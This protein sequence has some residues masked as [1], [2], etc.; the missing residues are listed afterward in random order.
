MALP[1]FSLAAQKIWVAQNLGELQPPPLA[2]T[3]M[4]L[5][6]WFVH[7]NLSKT[8]GLEIEKILRSPFGNQLEKCSGQMQIFSCQFV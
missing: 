2:R 8:T 6:Q 5:S 7:P 4:I 1:K 3:P